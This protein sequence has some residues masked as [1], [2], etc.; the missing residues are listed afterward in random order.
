MAEGHEVWDIQG[1]FLGHVLSTDSIVSRLLFSLVF[2]EIL[3]IAEVVENMNKKIGLIIWTF[4]LV[5]R[6]YMN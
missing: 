3:A 2:V 6:L 4:S 1:E 5:L